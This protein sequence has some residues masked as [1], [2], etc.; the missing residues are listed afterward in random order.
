ML[1]IYSRINRY[2]P[3]G[4]LETKELDGPWRWKDLVGPKEFGISEG[5]L[6]VATVRKYEKGTNWA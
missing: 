4:P 1:P 6:R 5:W 2:E 3:P